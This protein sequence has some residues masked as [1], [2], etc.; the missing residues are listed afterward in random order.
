MPRSLVKKK[1]LDSASSQSLPPLQALGP[2]PTRSSRRR[3]DRTPS[4]GSRKRAEP[5]TR[6][7]FAWFD[8]VALQQS[9]HGQ[10]SCCIQ[11]PC[12]NCG[13]KI[14]Q[15]AEIRR[16]GSEMIRPACVAQFKAGNFEELAPWSRI[17]AHN[18]RAPDRSGGPGQSRTADQRFR[19]PLLYPSELRGQRSNSLSHANFEFSRR[20]AVRNGP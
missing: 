19:K 5:D 10:G 11:M 4:T 20:W 15:P 17:G 13:R 7:V 14:Q 12:P 8:V 16:V 9:P 1:T 3:P 18:L 2:I 6:L